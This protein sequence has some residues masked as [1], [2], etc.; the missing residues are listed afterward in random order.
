MTKTPIW[1]ERAARRSSARSWTLGSVLEDYC[2]AER[3]PRERLAAW[4]DCDA[5]SLAWLALCRRPASD[6]F[7]ADVERIAER[8]RINALRLA[9]IIRRVEALDALRR[10]RLTS[11]TFLQLAAR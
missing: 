5:N 11:E 4:L 10:P 1:L 9:S 8:F 2:R 3:R 7:A 6:S